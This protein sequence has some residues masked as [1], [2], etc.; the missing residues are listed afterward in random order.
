MLLVQRWHRAGILLGVS[1]Y[2]ARIHAPRLRFYGIL[3]CKSA[4][5]SSLDSTS[6]HCQLLFTATMLA[7][8]HRKCQRDIRLFIQVIMRH[9]TR[10]ATGSRT[11]QL[12][13][14]TAQIFRNL[15]NLFTSTVSLVQVI[16]VRSRTF[17]TLLSCQLRI[18][19]A[20]QFIYE[21]NSTLCEL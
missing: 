18:R 9:L 8:K 21:T 4:H 13:S 5:D 12:L 6:A 3:H 2:V 19:P 1:V 15:T 7:P 10:L 11:K 20:P 17:C 14:R 16:V